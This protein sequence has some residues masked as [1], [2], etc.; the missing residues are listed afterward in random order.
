MVKRQILLHYA[1]LGAIL[2]KGFDGALET[3]TG[4]VLAITGPQRFYGWV[5]RLTAPELTGHHPALHAIRS[6]ATRLSEA[7]HEFVLFYLLVHGFL[8]LGIVMALLWRGGRLVFPIAALILAAFVVYMGWHLTMRWS[9][10]VLSFALFDLLTLGLVLNEW[11]NTSRH[12]N[13]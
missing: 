12:V 13:S 4:I 7:S 1:Y 9:G 11:R 10:W 3:L 2:I 5:I 6:G 8:K